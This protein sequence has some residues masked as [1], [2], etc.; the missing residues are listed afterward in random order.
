MDP[1][2]GLLA[3]TYATLAV[4]A[5]LQ[6]IPDE[7]L[8]AGDRTRWLLVTWLLPFVGA[9]WVVRRVKRHGTVLGAAASS[10]DTAKS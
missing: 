10:T 8:S 3:A 5:T 6:I 2:P 4:W 9:I 1:L 7:L